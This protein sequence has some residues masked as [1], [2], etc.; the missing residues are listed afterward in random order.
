MR[1]LALGLVPLALAVVV[2]VALDAFGPGG[3]PP[4]SGTSAPPSPV[5]G[6]VI[7]I[8]SAGLAQVRGFRLRTADGVVLDFTLGTL[9]DPTEFA[10]GHLAEH[11]ATSLPIRVFY[12]SQDDRLVVYRLEDAAEASPAASPVGT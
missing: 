7:R 10:P 12:R 9:E 3:T 2:A 1:R 6:I 5:V 4:V 8:D 11:L